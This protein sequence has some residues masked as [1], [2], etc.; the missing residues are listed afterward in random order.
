M[1]QAILGGSKKAG[2]VVYFN[3]G[4]DGDISGPAPDGYRPCPT[5]LLEVGGSAYCNAEFLRSLPDNA[6]IKIFFDGLPNLPANDYII[7]FMERDLREVKASL[8]K[9]E[10]HIINWA[11]KHHNIPPEMTKKRN[12]K[13]ERTFCAYRDYNQADIDHVLGIMEQRK[14][15]TLLRVNYADLIA[16]PYETLQSLAISPLGRERFK[17]D[18]AAAA[19]QIDSK[20]YRSRHDNGKDRS[21]ERSTDNQDRQKEEPN[22][23]C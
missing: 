23:H 19:A 7:I 10:R 5:P 22:A 14:D 2:R 6:I 12:A 8:E 13:V 18:V 17:L 11:L 21:K 15:V 9:A 16:N 20:Y 4:H 3:D 1:M